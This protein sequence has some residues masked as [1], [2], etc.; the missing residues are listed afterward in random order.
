MAVWSEHWL[1]HLPE[2]LSNA[3]AAPLMCAGSTVW[4]ALQKSPVRPTDR[5]GVVG[6]GGLGHVAVL[7]AKAMG[8]EVVVFSKTANKKDDARKLGADEF[9]VIEDEKKLDIGEPLDRLL[10]TASSQADWEL[11]VPLMAP[12]RLVPRIVALASASQIELTRRQ[13]GKLYPIT[14]AFDKLSIPYLPFLLSGLVL[15]GCSISSRKMHMDMLAFAARKNIKP[16][17][18]EFPMS[19]SGI[20]EAMSRLRSK[21]MRFR[22]VLTNS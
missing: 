17:I 4:T 21:K 6:L 22:A 1:F 3:D 18:E 7:F 16:W 5:V 14:I 11:F 19:V 12:V 15:E 9:F 8:C 10:V 13:E 2:G 20:T